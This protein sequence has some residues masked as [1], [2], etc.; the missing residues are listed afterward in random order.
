MYLSEK[1]EI[2]IR[3]GDQPVIVPRIFLDRAVVLSTGD[4]QGYADEKSKC[5]GSTENWLDFEDCDEIGFDRETNMFSYMKFNYPEETRNPL[6]LDRLD[7]IESISGSLDFVSI[8]KEHCL[9]P[10]K[11]RFY[12]ADRDTLFCFR[13]GFLESEERFELKL[14]P[15]ISFYFD[16]QLFSGWSLK[17]PELYLSD[18]RWEFTNQAK[19]QKLKEVFAEWM[20]IT[21]ATNVELMDQEQDPQLFERLKLLCE[22]VKNETSEAFHI[23]KYHINDLMEIFYRDWDQKK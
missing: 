6:T 22:Q 23:L 16:N 18:I 4:R 17:N 19:D 20:E 21:S 14:T 5:V 7:S 3:K 11:Y 10:L 13:D 12:D 1:F 9:R 8:E 2:K 15:E